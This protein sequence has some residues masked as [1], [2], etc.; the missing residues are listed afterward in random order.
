MDVG[1][2]RITAIREQRWEGAHGL[3]GKPLDGGLAGGRVD[4]HSGA[5]GAPLVGLGREIGEVPEGPQRPEV[6]PDIGDGALLH[7][8]LFL[9]VSPGAGDRGALQGPQKRSK[10]VVE[11]HQRA[12]AFQARGEHGVMDECLGGPWKK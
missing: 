4:C 2:S 11:P 5:L 10:V 7:L 3:G 9:G 6:V 12:L 1:V 8:A